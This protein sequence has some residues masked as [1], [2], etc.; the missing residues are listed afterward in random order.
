MPNNIIPIIIIE[1]VS[2]VYSLIYQRVKGNVYPEKF[3]WRKKLFTILGRIYH[4]PQEQ[5]HTV[6]DEMIKM[7][8][9]KW[10]KRDYLEI[11]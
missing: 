5:R 1:K 7:G 3:V 4:I 8:L 6:M 11:L 10:N 9:L 2:V